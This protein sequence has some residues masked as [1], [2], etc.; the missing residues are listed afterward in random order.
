M[1]VR[2]WNQGK[3]Y[4]FGIMEIIPLCWCGLFF[5]FV[6]KQNTRP[7]SVVVIKRNITDQSR[8][9][10]QLLLER[11]VDVNV[12]DL[13]GMTPSMWACR[14]DHIEHFS[15]LS[16]RENQPGSDTDGFDRDCNGRTWLHWSVRR[17]EPLECLRVSGQ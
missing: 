1:A 15:E 2:L 12:R 5:N 7:I 16:A 10:W 11:G 8:S 4:V 14:T 3:S 13:E 9:R 17:T 6:T